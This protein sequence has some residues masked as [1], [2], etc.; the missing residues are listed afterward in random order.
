M[1]P[2]EATAPRTLEVLDRFYRFHAPIYNWSRPFILF[3]RRTLLRQLGH[4]PPTTDFLVYFDE[5]G[6]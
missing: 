4:T 2:P 1:R 3:G 5:G 6:R